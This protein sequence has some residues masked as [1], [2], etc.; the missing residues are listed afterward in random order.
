[1]ALGAC[2]FEYFSSEFYRE[3]LR[4]SSNGVMEYYDPTTLIK[5]L[6]SVLLTRPKNAHMSL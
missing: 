4:R 5:R 3:L 1:M 6:S 2:T